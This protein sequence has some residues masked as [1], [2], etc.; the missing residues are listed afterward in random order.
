[1][2]AMSFL[3]VKKDSFSSFD[4]SSNMSVCTLIVIEEVGTHC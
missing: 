3:K 1:M 4:S 2:N